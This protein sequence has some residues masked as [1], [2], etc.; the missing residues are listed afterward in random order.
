M[1][2]YIFVNRT[3]HDTGGDVPPGTSGAVSA[4]CEGKMYVFGG[5]TEEG[6]TNNLYC[7][8]LRELKWKQIKPCS[9]QPSPRDKFTAWC[10]DNKYV[11]CITSYSAF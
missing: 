11:H 8:D 9:E 6:N 5:H 1:C 3:R 4:L 10:Y 2:I 7:L